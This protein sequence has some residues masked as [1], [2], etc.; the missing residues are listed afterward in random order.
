MFYQTTGKPV[1]YQLFVRLFGNAKIPTVQ[2]GTMEENGCGKFNDVSDAALQ[3]LK[4]MGVT[5]IWF[6]GIVEHATM[7]DFTAFNIQPDDWRLVK[8]RA[9]SPFAVKDYF[10][11]SPDLAVNVNKRMQEFE[12]L[13]ERTHANG[14][15]AIID[16][17]PNHVA[18]GYHSDS[19]DGKRNFFGAFDDTTKTFDPQNNFYYL[20]DQSFYPPSEYHPLGMPYPDH[21]ISHVEM[22]A[23][24]TGNNVF[25]SSPGTND[26]FETVKLNFGIDIFNEHRSYFDP[27]P[28]TWIYLREVLLF[29][30]KKGVDGFRCDMAE[31]VPAE[32]WNWLI[33]DLKKGNDVLFIAEV[34]EKHLYHKYIYDAGFDYLY[35]KA[36]MY[37]T[38]VNVLKGNIP[39]WKISDV[40]NFNISDRL[41]NFMENHDEVRLASDS[42]CGQAWPAIPAVVVSSMLTKGSFMIYNGQETGDNAMDLAG[43][44]GGNG[45]TT[46]Y[47]YWH[48][49]ELQKWVNNGA[50]DGGLLN[51]SQQ[52][53]R[54]TYS[55]ILNLIS[56]NSVFSEGSL[57]VLTHEITSADFNDHSDYIY[58]FI[59]FRN[60]RRILSIVNF[61]QQ[62][63][64]PVRVTLK[65]GLIEHLGMK[66]LY[67]YKA[68]E[69]L[70]GKMTEVNYKGEQEGYEINL[71]LPLS[72]AMI[73]EITS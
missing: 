39:A 68:K 13:I 34:Y 17:I 52:H 29:W 28:R 40:S 3:S 61:D 62:H 5:H 30:V 41:M 25:S 51:A 72:S 69:L 20:P 67:H 19:D 44:G 70:T 7:S 32:F 48:I 63:Y 35:D 50:Y 14:M 47:D 9:G 59:R 66:E 16:F 21:M 73:F 27:V 22:P 36:C 60:D 2:N 55:S 26:W 1:I 23:R 11:V 57:Y 15:K 46:I 33:H 45:R 8:G 37:D 58:A 18:R 31:M 65:Q 42:I 6:T 24:V 10:D 38:L 71:V 4:K 53:L 49:P 56:E 54:R 43:F 12:E 64:V